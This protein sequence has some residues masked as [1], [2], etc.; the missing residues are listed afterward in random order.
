MPPQPT[1]EHFE[2]LLAFELSGIFGGHIWVEGE[3]RC[4][5]KVRIPDELFAQMQKCASIQIEISL[6][7]RVRRV[8]EEYGHYDPQI[9]REKTQSITKRM[10]G[11]RVKISLE[12]LD[13]GDM[14]AWVIPLLEYYDKTY[15]HSIESRI[16]PPKKWDINGLTMEEIIR[17]IKLYAKNAS[18]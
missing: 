9:L 5:G 6:A 11:D 16:I 12:A 15:L 4:I 18:A 3:S 1:Q 7:S 8:L 14:Q 10:G 17:E 2:N 13:R